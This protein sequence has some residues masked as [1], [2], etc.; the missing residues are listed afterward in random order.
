M[1][2]GELQ[3][4]PAEGLAPSLLVALRE[5]RFTLEGLPPEQEKL[6]GCDACRQALSAVSRDEAPVARA[7]VVGE[8]LANRYVLLEEL[9]RGAMGV[10]FKA[11]D[12]QLERPVAVKL[13][14]EDAVGGL[15]REDRR[16]RLLREGR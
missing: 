1:R 6:A 14:R 15:E 8:L 5:K 13:L 11:F 4:E 10:V 3:D 7:S 16:Q 12:T 2:R 9:G